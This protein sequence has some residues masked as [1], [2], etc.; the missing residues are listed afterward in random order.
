MNFNSNKECGD[1]GTICGESEMRWIEVA[2]VLRDSDHDLG[3][4]SYPLT[5]PD[6]A[7]FKA[8]DISGRS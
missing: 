7:R 4:T 1:V 2:N 8:L 3:C 5:A 6:M